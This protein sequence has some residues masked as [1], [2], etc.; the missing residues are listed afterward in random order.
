MTKEEILAVQQSWRLL[1]NRMDDI[2][3]KFYENLFE[4][5]PMF[6]TLFTEGKAKQ[7]SK[8]MNLIGLTVT[9]LNL[10]QPDQTISTVGK[11]HVAY[12]VKPEYF[13]KFGEVLM[14]TFKEALKDNWT[15]ELESAWTKAYANMADLMV[16]AYRE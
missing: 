4:E 5:V 1:M 9:K 15:P 12:G 6:E 14:K 10:E 13:A 7:G 2:G 8:L 16:K 11:R 3:E